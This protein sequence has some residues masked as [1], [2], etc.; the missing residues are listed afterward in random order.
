MLQTQDSMF[1]VCTLSKMG[2][3]EV[4]V[5]SLLGGQLI[6][7]DTMHSQIPIKNKHNNDVIMNVCCRHAWSQIHE[8]LYLITFLSIYI[9]I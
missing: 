1:E 5:C 6:M 4:V 2:I 9:C 8:Y 7:F 3:H